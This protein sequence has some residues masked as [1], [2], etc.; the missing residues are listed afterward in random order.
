MAELD[1]LVVFQSLRRWLKVVLFASLAAAGITA[2]W[3]AFAPAKYTARVVLTAIGP[4][5]QGLSLSGAASSLLG[6]A[7]NLGGSEGIQATPDMVGYL[8]NS[9]TVLVA[10]AQAPPAGRLTAA[11]VVREDVVLV[12][13]RIVAGADPGDR[14]G[15]RARRARRDRAAATAAEKAVDAAVAPVLAGRRIAGVLLR[16]VIGLGRF[17]CRAALDRQQRQG[18]RPDER[19]G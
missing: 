16:S 9:E 18:R 1:L 6:V 12:V 14:C 3:A 13:A 2:L 19:H 8:L 15:L 17:R 5:K 10:V 7:L 11:I 4:G